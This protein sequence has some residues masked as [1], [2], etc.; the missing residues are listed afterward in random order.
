M[1]NMGILL[2]Y[3][4]IPKAIFYLLKGHCTCIDA[5]MSAQRFCRVEIGL[6]SFLQG[7]RLTL[8]IL[9]VLHDLGMLR[10]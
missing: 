4:N 6:T 8:L 9:K 2:T 3:Y 5:E 10:V 1:G 7:A